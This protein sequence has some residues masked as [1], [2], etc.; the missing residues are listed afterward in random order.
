MSFAAT[1]IATVG[2]GLAGAGASYLSNQSTNKAM[3]GAN[4]QVD[5]KKLQSNAIA[6]DKNAFA[7]SDSDY[8]ARHPEA[9]QAE[10]G[11]EAQNLRDQAQIASFNP[12]DTGNHTLMPQLQSEM[13]RA[14][15]GNTLGAFGDTGNTLGIGSAGEASVARNLGLG[16]MGF[17][18]NELAQY[19]QR[20]NNNQ[21]L[22][23]STGAS[24][25]EVDQLAPHR[26]FGMSGSDIANLTLGQ[27][28]TNNAFNQQMIAT[29]A[30]QNQ[31][32]IG[33][34]TSSL[35]GG[36]GTYQQQKNFNT[37]MA[38]YNNRTNAMPNGTP[39]ATPQNG[40]GEFATPSYL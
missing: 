29:K 5:L 28:A 6:T 12:N 40:N 4:Q 11:L 30:N 32:L 10:Q 21:A 24:I 37:N 3:A 39:V 17:Q 1:A 15:L 16:I 23:A 14:G 34:L 25:G 26:T 20:F 7:L 13:M 2:V 38:A 33:G 36:I 19:Q 27:N 22:K 8:L 31:A 9:V 35:T 18:N